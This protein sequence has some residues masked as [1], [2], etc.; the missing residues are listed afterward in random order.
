MKAIISSLSLALVVLIG[1]CSTPRTVSTMEG[2][3]TKQTFNASF[4]QVWRAAVD[5]AQQGDLA[6][7]SADR[8][9]GYISARRGV[10][11]E[12]FGENVGIWIKSLSPTSTQVEV[13]SRQSGPPVLWLKNW[14]NEIMRTIQANL[15]REA[16]AVG[17]PALP[18][19]ETEG[20][21]ALHREK[22][23]LRLETQSLLDDLHAKE[24]LRQEELDREL[25]GQRR[26][27]L[28]TEMERIREEL[29]RMESRLKELEEQEQKLR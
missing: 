6:I 25:D 15:T 27:Q 8:E 29:R 19:Y 2:R 21:S 12:T 5:S 11:L 1:G 26:E 28:R 4:D 7:L 22:E 23:K 16:P 3:G 10:R 14:E 20:T 9:R 24:K 13:V 17:A 18:T